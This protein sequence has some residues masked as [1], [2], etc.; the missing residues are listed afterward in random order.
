[1]Y[2]L[3]TRPA[4]AH[5]V[6]LVVRAAFRQGNN[7]VDFL[8]RNVTSLLQAHLAERMLV[9]VA[10]A[11]ALPGAS[12]SFAGRVAARELLVEPCAPGSTVRRPRTGS[13]SPDSGRAVSVSLA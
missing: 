13:G 12:V 3:V 2:L 10:C 4:Q 8:D 5:E 9:D 1:M 6:A 11:D 7:V